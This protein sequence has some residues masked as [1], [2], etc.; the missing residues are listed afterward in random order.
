MFMLD[1]LDNLP[2]LRLSDDQLKTIIWIMRECK[3]PDVPSFTALRKK[4]AQLTREVK[5]QTLR[6][7][8]AMGNEF[9]MNHP[10]ELLAL[11]SISS[12][13][14]A[15]SDE[16]ETQDWA[17]P[18]V[19]EFIQVYPEITNHISEFNQAEKWTKEIDLDDL[20]P[21]WADWKRNGDKHF[22][23]KE[24]AQLESGRF[25]IPIRWVIVKKEV[26]ADIYNVIHY[27]EVRL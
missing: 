4:Q 15:L 9:Y 13:L 8:S 1:L 16:N 12:S 24:L 26:H 5:L 3:T 20:S 25:V 21:M 14:V 2:R 23:V 27:P 10:A 19:R 22:Y 18:L 6:H 7:T 11:V 17:N